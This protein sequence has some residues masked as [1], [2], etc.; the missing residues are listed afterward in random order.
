[1]EGQRARAAAGALR[2]AVLWGALTHP[3]NTGNG[4]NR[5]TCPRCGVQRTF[6][7]LNTLRLWCTA[8]QAKEKKGLRDSNCSNT[9]PAALHCIAKKHFF[10]A[11]G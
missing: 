5:R 8:L 9:T 11:A 7:L 4:R 2:C 10:S 3:G 1:M 6:Q